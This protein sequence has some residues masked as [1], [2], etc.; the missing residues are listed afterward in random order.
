MDQRPLKIWTVLKENPNT[1]FS[2][3]DNLQFEAF[4]EKR[5]KMC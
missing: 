3:R 4:K 1:T 5:V 2:K